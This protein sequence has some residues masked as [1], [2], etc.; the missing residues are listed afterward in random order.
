M[1]SKAYT[2]ALCKLSATSEPLE[3]LEFN[4]STLQEPVR[5]V[6]DNQPVVSNGKTYYP[7]AFA[8]RYPDAGATQ[9][10]KASVQIDNI[11]PEL[12]QLLDQRLGAK[13][14]SIKILHVMRETP[15]I[16]DFEHIFKDLK[17]LVITP[18]TLSFELGYTKV[19]DRQAVQQY[20]RPETAEGLF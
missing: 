3:L 11:N 13:N 14:A 1:P 12:A 19:L 15:D 9:Q 16:I 6:K 8:I 18:K 20:Y 4:H 5:L 7:C 17:G 2:E 10:P